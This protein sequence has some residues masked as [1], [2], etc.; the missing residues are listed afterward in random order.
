MER[1]KLDFGRMRLWPLFRAMFVPTLIG[2]ICTSLLTVVDG[3]FVGQGVGEYGIAAVN[4]VAPL[5]MVATGIG[6][7][8]GIGA[9]VIAGIRLSQDNVKAAR[10]IMTQGF[11]ASSLLALAIVVAMVVAPDAMLGM[12]G[13]SDRLHSLAIDYMLPLTGAIFFVMIQCIG[14]MLIRLDGSPKYAM[15][16]QAV[17]AVINIVLDYVMIFPM[18]MGV[19]GAAVATSISCIIGGLMALGYFVWF[20]DKLRFYRLRLTVRSLR[21]SLRNVGYMARIGFATFLSEIAMSVM[22][23]TGNYVFMERLREPGV[24][25][26]SIACYLFPVVFSMANAVAQSAQPIISYN[27]GADNSG[28]VFSTLRLALRTAIVCG[29][30]VAVGLWLG[31]RGVVSLFLSPDDA[32]YSIAVGG[33]PLFATCAIFFAVNITFIGFYQ[34]IERPF[35]AICYTL[36]RGIILL[37]PAFILLPLLIGDAGLWLAIPSAEALTTIIILM[38][39]RHS[40][41]RLEPA[42]KS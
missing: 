3:M 27:Y 23:I 31:A 4:I 35:K 14:M 29:I 11:L 37:V 16:C 18:G 24:A 1:D 42:R 38:V 12:L 21:L 28:R 6:L 7:M 22:M 32:A 13:C 10:I 25:A 41:H 39:A 33:L 9:S 26:Y 5:Y 17:P 20:A 2:M 15:W 30:I 8:F 40:F 36:L 19:R 34:S